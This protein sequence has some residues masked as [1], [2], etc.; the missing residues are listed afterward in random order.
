MFL[1]WLARGR[2][3][4]PPDVLGKAFAAVGALFLV[5]PVCNPWYCAWLLPF[6][7]LFGRVSWVVLASTMIAYYVHW[8]TGSFIVDTPIPLVARVDLRLL[9]YLPFYALLALEELRVRFPPGR[10][11]ALDLLRHRGRPAGDRANGPG[12]KALLRSPKGRG[13]GVSLTLLI[14]AIQFEVQPHLRSCGADIWIENIEPDQVILGYRNPPTRRVELRSWLDTKLTQLSGGKGGW[15]IL[16]EG[17]EACGRAEHSS[18][19][20]ER[21]REIA[22]LRLLNRK[23]A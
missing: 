17:A 7:A 4:A 14:E 6:A 18:R 23:A 3:E 20:V 15:V 10:L 1:V 11:M 2:D 13:S 19:E 8:T 9:E 5:S 16:T 12:G 21:A 22:R